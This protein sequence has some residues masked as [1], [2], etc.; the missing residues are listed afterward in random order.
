MPRFASTVLRTRCNLLWRGQAGDKGVRQR[1][2][3]VLAATLSHQAELSP[4]LAEELEATLLARL[5]DK[6][7]AVRAEAAKALSVFADPGPVRSP[8][9]LLPCLCAC[10][11][12]Y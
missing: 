7:P 12:Q 4:E 10:W 2:C 6:H 5:R 1:V 3:Q 8:W 9:T 11:R